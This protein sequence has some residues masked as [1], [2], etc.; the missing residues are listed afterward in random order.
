MCGSFLRIETFP[1]GDSGTH[2]RESPNL[3]DLAGLLPQGSVQIN[4]RVGPPSVTERR[5][6]D[7]SSCLQAERRV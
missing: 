6:P 4:A 1:P 2:V 5:V 7:L 3:Q